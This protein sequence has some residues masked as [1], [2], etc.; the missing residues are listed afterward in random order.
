VMHG[1]MLTPDEAFAHGLVDELVEPN[2]LMPRALARAEALAE[3]PRSAY[4]ATKVN[5]RGP[6]VEYT[7]ARL[8]PEM[9]ALSQ[10]LSGRG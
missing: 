3:L 8:E 6:S 2:E 10:A 9:A 5:V 4:Q 1:V 7:R